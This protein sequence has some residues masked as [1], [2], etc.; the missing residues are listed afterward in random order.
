MAKC[1]KLASKVNFC[2]WEETIKQQ[3][4]TK[5]I[6]G[7]FAKLAASSSAKSMP[8][9]ESTEKGIKPQPL[10]ESVIIKT[11]EGQED[12]L[13]TIPHD[14]HHEAQYV[15]IKAEPV[16]FI[17]EWKEAKESEI[18]QSL[19]KESTVELKKRKR[20]ASSDKLLRNSPHKRRKLNATVTSKESNAFLAYF[21]K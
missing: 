3:D 12:V 4:R 14:E 19:P 7:M 20:D 11:E 10:L 13:S 18:T 17:Q 6:A 2:S 5:G 21:K 16:D 8:V 15:Q 9:S 1:S